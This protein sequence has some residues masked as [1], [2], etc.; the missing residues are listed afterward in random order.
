MTADTANG[1]QEFSIP[2]PDDACSASARKS[3][4]PNAVCGG[5]GM[6][7]P[8]HGISPLSGVVIYAPDGILFEIY[9]ISREPHRP[10]SF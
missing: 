8:E 4:L 10:S 7:R 2:L 9:N 1:L 6:Q 5:G 3:Q